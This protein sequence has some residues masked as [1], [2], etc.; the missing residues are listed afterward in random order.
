MTHFILNRQAIDD[1][2]DP[3]TVVLDLIRQRPSLTGTKDVCREGD[4][5][6]C[7]V[8]L[9]KMRGGRLRYQAVNACLLPL[10]AI[11][12]CHV[13]TVEGLN[14]EF[15]NPIQRALVDCG[16]I[17]CGFCT[18][19]LVMALTGFFLNAETSNEQAAIDA[20][21]GNLCRCTGYA[22]I[23]RAIARLCRQ[24]DL[25]GSPPGRRIDDLVQWQIL[26][27]YFSDIAAKLSAIAPRSP[28]EPSPDAILVGGGTDLWVGRP[29][30]LHT[31]SLAFLPGSAEGVRF[32]A[33]DCIIDAATTIEQLQT[34]TLFRQWFP[35][36]TQDFELICSAPVRA[37]ATVGGNLVNASPI[38]DLAVFFL[39]LNARLLLVSHNAS[40]TVS[41]KDFFQGYKQVDLQSGERLQA[42]RFNRTAAQG[43][44]YEKVGMRRHLDIAAV[45]SALGIEHDDG[46]IVNARLSAG[47]VAPVP[48]YFE[49][50]SAYL[51]G[52]P[53]TPATVT[54]AAD[55]A[56]QEIAP[57]SDLRGSADYKRL[58]LRQLIFAHFMK[59]F[60]E[61]IRWEPLHARQ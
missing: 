19:G 46:R 60:P 40:R 50:T 25:S 44:S 13:V 9:G 45:N 53:I 58:L 3:A 49:K 38:A 5:G 31:Q 35:S 42:I 4:C 27:A 18:P 52:R 7:Q 43:F 22:G 26:P 21:A 48:F 57:I 32:D 29:H 11:D 24:F 33:D 20:I 55:I 47:G 1:H 59:L 2:A 34:S 17:Q 8:L 30:S 37:R 54:A 41:L 16:A 36:I 15:L 28:I 6:A 56:R 10:G 14:A 39:A 23:K 12:A 51:Q 61:A